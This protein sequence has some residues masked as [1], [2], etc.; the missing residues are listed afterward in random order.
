MTDASGTRCFTLEELEADARRRL[1]PTGLAVDFT[2]EE[3]PANT[4]TEPPRGPLYERGCAVASSVYAVYPA[5]GEV[6]LEVLIRQK[7][8]G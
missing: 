6:A 5:P 2:V 8:S 3:R 4:G 1:T 7:A